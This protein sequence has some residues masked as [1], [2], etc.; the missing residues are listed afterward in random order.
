MHHPHND[1]SLLVTRSQLVVLIVPLDDLNLT[2]VALKI[3]VHGEVSTALAFSCVKLQHLEQTGVTSASDVAFLLVPP[4]HIQVSSI[5][6][7]NLQVRSYE[8]ILT[9]LDK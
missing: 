3:L 7:S 6:H 5:G 2:R 4:D 8:L 1:K 9:F